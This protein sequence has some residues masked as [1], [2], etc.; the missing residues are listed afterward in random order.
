[1]RVIAFVYDNV[2]GEVKQAEDT[3]LIILE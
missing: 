3:E 1:L 2:S